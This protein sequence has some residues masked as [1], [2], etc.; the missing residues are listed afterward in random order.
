MQ[1]SALPP[2]EGQGDVPELM[3]HL[4]MTNKNHNDGNHTGCYPESESPTTDLLLVSPCQTVEHLMKDAQASPPQ[5][6]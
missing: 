2:L 4:Y 5:L 3:S 6:A 1:V